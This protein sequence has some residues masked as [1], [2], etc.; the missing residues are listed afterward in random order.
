[1]ASYGNGDERNAPLTTRWR[2]FSRTSMNTYIMSKHSNGVTV[3]APLHIFGFQLLMPH[4]LLE[5]DKFN[6]RFSCDNLPTNT[7]D[8]LRYFRYKKALLQREVADFAGIDRCTYNSYENRIRDIIPLGKLSLVASILE[9]EIIDL[10]DDYNLFIYNGQGGQVKR[11]RTTIGL[12]QKEFGEKI[13]VNA[14]TVKKWENERVR[15]SKNS[16]KRIFK[17]EFSN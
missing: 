5:A 2:L 6:N 15:I 14:S 13:K 9:V 7:A 8:K 10:L 16:W 4:S 3:Y 12:T 1:M 17:E 11:L